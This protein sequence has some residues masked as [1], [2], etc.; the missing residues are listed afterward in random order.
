MLHP[1][2]SF[3]PSN[4]NYLSQIVC[5]IRCFFVTLQFVI[6]SLC[7][8][9]TY[10]KRLLTLVF[11]NPNYHIELLTKNKT[12]VDATG[13]LHIPV[14]VPRALYA[15]MH[16]LWVYHILFVGISMFVG[17]H[18]CGRL[19]LQANGSKIPTFF[20]Y[21]VTNLYQL[22]IALSGYR[23]AANQLITNTR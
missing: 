15:I 5:I 8:D 13:R 18:S 14:S 23:R 6:A 20:C 10:K 17:Q 12:D 2:S 3:R 11:S 9:T 22:T 1:F 19:G 21:V 16:T 7:S 4:W